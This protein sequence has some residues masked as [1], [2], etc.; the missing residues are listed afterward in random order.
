METCENNTL[1]LA[2][3]AFNSFMIVLG[4]IFSYFRHQHIMS[5]N[6]RLLHIIESKTD[7]PDDVK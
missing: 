3:I 5:D 4:L 1:N 6:R 7:S 2:L